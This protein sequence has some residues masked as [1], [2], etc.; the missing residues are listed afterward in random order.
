VT[1]DTLSN[2]AMLRLCPRTIVSPNVRFRAARVLPGVSSDSPGMCQRQALPD[3]PSALTYAPAS[4]ILDQLTPVQRAILA[5]WHRAAV[6]RETGPN[7]ASYDM[8]SCGKRG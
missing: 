1:G 5:Y 2:R 6:A 8:H 3:R 7:R 4:I